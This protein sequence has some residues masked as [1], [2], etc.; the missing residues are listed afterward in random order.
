M[1]PKV[2][3][4]G[5]SIVL[6]MLAQVHGDVGPA[7]QKI[8]DYVVREPEQVIYMSITELAEIAGTS[9]A[10]AVRLFKEIGYKGFQDF[11]I[12]LSQSLGSQTQ[13]LDREVSATATPIE[14]LNS[15]FATSISTIQDTHQVID[16]E[17]LDR[18]VDLLATAKRIEFMGVGGSGVVAY[19][20]YHKFLRIGIPVNACLDPHNAVQT[21][22][23]LGKGDLVVFISHSGSTRD[24]LDAAQIAKDAGASAIAI[25]RY[26]R[27]PL[28]RIVDVTLQTMSPETSYRSEGIASRIAQLTLL[29]ALMV[30]TFL[31][32]QPEAAENLKRSREALTTKRL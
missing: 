8:I 10:S 17:A 32:R 22:A 1:T 3:G 19:D 5:S 28:Q 31:R 16:V 7:R 20:G 18:A 11:K 23:V 14:V 4:P 24:I 15:V 27:S 2:K 9:E 30:N 12:A 21:C 29:D 6:K 13:E 26:G 25:T